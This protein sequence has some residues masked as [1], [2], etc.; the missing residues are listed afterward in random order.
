MSGRRTREERRS[1]KADSG[2][3]AGAHFPVHGSP[4]LIHLYIPLPD[5]IRVPDR[6]LL[7]VSYAWN[8]MADD[9]AC[10]RLPSRDGVQYAARQIIIFH[11]DE[12]QFDL[13]PAKAAMKI[14]AFALEKSGSLAPAGA[15]SPELSITQTTAEVV[16]VLDPSQADPVN[17]GL[18][19]AL[20]VIRDFQTY[21]HLFT[22]IPT[23]R[24]TRKILPPF[25]PMIRRTA[26]KP[27]EWKGELL[28][29]NNGGTTLH[30]ALTPAMSAEQLKILLKHN[31][32]SR[33]EVFK[34]FVLMRQEA[35]ASYAAGSN[36][37]TCLFI[38]IAAETLLTELF[39]LLSWEDDADLKRTA[40]ALGERDNIS[41][42]LL[43]ELA[44]ML[45]GDWDRGGKGPIG[46]WQLRV[47]TLRNDVAHSG[48][49][50]SDPEIEVALTTLSDLE[51][52][53]GDQLA[54]E[55]NRYPLVSNM[56]LGN[57]G[58]ERRNKLKRWKSA[59]AKVQFPRHASHLFSR[60]KTEVQRIRSGPHIGRLSESTTTVVLFGNGAER[61]YLVD[62]GFDLSCPVDAPALDP[63]TRSNLDK[64][65][66]EGR[67]DVTSVAVPFCKPTPPTTPKWMPSYQ[68]LPTTSIG[69][70]EQC[71][72]VPPSGP[73]T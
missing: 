41:R 61:W 23:R 62:D 40:S 38:A 11:Q 28:H 39:L 73:T 63:G 8:P 49:I 47:A 42:R 17:H 10:F 2:N 65:R 27:D 20:D 45:K 6:T 13:E 58:L 35:L 72:W 59:S 36:S 32:T 70:W 15:R 60:W 46:E 33:A 14:M 22:K 21:Y 19:Q 44:S 57:D 16:C 12:V 50:P 5:P 18:E 54:K 56:F 71:L 52:Y 3:P 69:R 67:F 34:A 25:I 9:G 30:S 48:K 29:L 66:A 31:E 24:V 7:P 64:I 53:V 43:S 51:A 4:D 68:V 55:V 1:Q 26:D 37:A